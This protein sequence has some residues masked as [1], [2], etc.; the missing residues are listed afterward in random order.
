MESILKNILYIN[1]DHRTDRREH[2]IEEFKK[3][4]I[5]GIERFPAVKMGLGNIGCTFSHIRCLELAKMR[6]WDQVFICE[7]DITFVNPELFLSNLRKFVSSGISWDVLVIGG[8]NAP[9]FIP[10]NDF[11]VRVQNIQTTTGYIVKKEYY[12]TLLSNFKEGVALLIREPDKKKQF[13]I[14]I[15]WKSLQS[16]DRWYLLIPLSVIQ[17]YDYS[18]IEE[19]V[20]DYGK[21]MLDLDKRELI[22]M[23]RKE[24]EKKRRFDMPGSVQLPFKMGIPKI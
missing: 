11:C 4:G 13:S 12:D 3:I 21:M 5:E 17:Y 20:M 16:R 8:N 2:V 6:D 7:D 19:K 22:E 14:D 10:I 23:L 18:D 24:E 9:P 1:L 15:Y